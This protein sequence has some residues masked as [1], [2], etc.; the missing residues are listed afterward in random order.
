MTAPDPGLDALLAALRGA[1]IQVGVDEIL[2]LRLVFARAAHLD[3]DEL[4]EVIAAV[5]VKSVEERAVFDQ[6]F[7]GWLSSAERILA[8]PETRDRKA[9][10]RVVQ[11]TKGR[12]FRRPSL[13]RL[14]APAILA[15]AV[16]GGAAGVHFWPATNGPPDP[17]DAGPAPIPSASASAAPIDAPDARPTTFPAYVPTITVTRVRP[18]RIV[19]WA[20]ATFVLLTGV[21]LW[22]IVSRRFALP[23]RDPLPTRPGPPAIRISPPSARGPELLGARDEEA[24]VG[25]VR[26]YVSEE[27]THALD[28]DRSVSATV[29]AAGLPT[30]RFARARHTR[31]VWLWID[32]SANDPT[33]ARYASEIATS[34][35]QVGLPVEEAT[36]WAVPDLLRRRDR[37]EVTPGE[38]DERRDA[39][40]VA[41]LTDGR[42]LRKAH[43]AENQRRDLSALLRGL[44]GWPRLAFADFAGGDHDLAGILRPHGIPILPPAQLAAFLAGDLDDEARAAV[45]SGDDRDLRGDARAWAAACALCPEPVDEETAL[46]LRR[47][48]GLRAP[49]PAI[50]A[51]WASARGVGG[52]LSWSRRDRAALLGWL[53]HAEALD[54]R[55]EVPEKSLLGSALQF[56]DGV[57]AAEDER[58]KAADAVVP[59]NDTPAERNLRMKR[60]LL[61]LWDRP[62]ASAK[63]LYRLYEGE[64]AEEI[65]AHVS[66]LLPRDGGD[67]AEGVVL[68]W[69]MAD[70][71][72]SARV[73]LGAMGMGSACRPVRREVLKRPGRL[74]LAVGVCVGAGVGMVGNVVQQRNTLTTHHEGQSPPWTIIGIDD[75]SDTWSLATQFTDTEFRVPEGFEATVR[76]AP[77]DAPCTKKLDGGA[78][79][80]WCGSQTR[81]KP[82]EKVDDATSRAPL[83][84]RAVTLYAK[85]SDPGART[86]ATRLLD[87]DSA[88]VVMFTEELTYDKTR[89]FA[90]DPWSATNWSITIVPKRRDITLRLSSAN[91]VMSSD[92]TWTDMADALLFQ[93]QRPMSFV[94]PSVGV[95]QGSQEP[96]AEADMEL[97]L[98]VMLNGVGAPPPAPVPQPRCP[99]GMVLI[100]GGTFTMGPSEP[101]KGPAHEVKL[102]HPYCM[103]K[104]EV[105]VAAYRACTNIARN[106]VQCASTAKTDKSGRCNEYRRDRED[107]PINCARW[108]QADAYCRWTGG[109]LPTEAEWEYAARGALGQPYPWGKLAPKET[110]LNACG[111]ECAITRQET[112]MYPG[113]DGWP[114]SAPVGTFPAGA[115]P[116]GLLDMAGNVSE[117]VADWYEPYT[118][119]KEPALD[120]KGPDKPIKDPRHIMRGGAWDNLT[121]SKVSTTYRLTLAT[122]DNHTVG[123]RC[124]RDPSQ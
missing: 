60:A 91:T 5:L 83:V 66:W 33:L 28:L 53:V 99:E 10:P 81:N 67:T 20:A 100:P 22:I 30:L 120:P 47:H 63:T 111:S 18:P 107:H 93:G 72:A 29:R 65:E 73:M 1:G 103:D 58:R 87:G 36:F 25:G 119:P 48:L 46:A 98:Y 7:S 9:A 94:W 44:S 121:P 117:W 2:R 51:L 31:E 14:A 102:S 124:A 122:S 56:W 34:L 79:I 50:R 16:A 104:N 92:A 6:V 21:A 109:R 123:F 110:L 49:P 11:T 76:W 35:R 71:P 112:A 52:K 57:Y 114:E 15:A 4:R 69:R 75:A 61:G 38:L 101:D 118:R 105:T 113:N 39:A 43:E 95:F 26:R 116:F 42:L 96:F 78:E 13:R 54:P 84:R 59:W 12:S 90:R 24:L 82:R 106:G 97:P 77:G 62:D 8:P 64:T 17:A 80:W 19:E 32:E 86:L 40:V 55:G 68:P 23:P 37:T 27:P 108:D 70:R 41:V 74:S 3:G 45:V 115:S 89:L 88:D 85:P